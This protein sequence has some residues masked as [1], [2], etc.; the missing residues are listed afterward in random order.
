MSEQT[1]QGFTRDFL[2]SLFI[3]DPYTGKVVRRIRR[4]TQLAG[5]V[6]GSVDGKG[7]LH[8]SVDKRFIR[9]HRLIWFM[10]T[11]A[12]PEHGIDHCNNNRR[13][14]RWDNLRLA[15]QRGNSGNILPPKHNTSGFKGVSRNNKTGLWHAQ[16]KLHG[17]QTYLGRFSDPLPAALVYNHAAEQHFGAFAK[18]NDV[19]GFGRIGIH[20]NSVSLFL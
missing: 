8:V 14:N 13:D 18:L 19:P 20:P 10:E 2:C 15:D 1:L 6:V 9:L 3:Y 5:T 11:G 4:R 7:Y 16:I 12:V 17:K